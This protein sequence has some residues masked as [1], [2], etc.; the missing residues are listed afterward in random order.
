MWKVSN[1]ARTYILHTYVWCVLLDS[2]HCLPRILRNVSFFVSECYVLMWSVL[3]CTAVCCS[4]LQC[5]AV[6]CSES[7]C[8]AVRCSVL[9]L[10]LVWNVSNFDGPFQMGDLFH[11]CALLCLSVEWCVLLDSKHCLPRILRNVSECLIFWLK[12]LCLG[13]ECFECCTHVYITHLCL[14]CFIRF[15]TLSA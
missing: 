6:C 3:Q 11:K 8:V 10:I 14:M 12:V 7:Q 1:V 15:Q 2:K 4:V 5:V 13:V 9:R